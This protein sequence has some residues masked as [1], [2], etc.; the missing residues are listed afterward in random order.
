VIQ[1]G[2]P[3]GLAGNTVSTHRASTLEKM[4]THNDVQ[5]PPYA[6]RHGHR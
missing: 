2:A 6:E 1:I 3:L 5:L 4:G